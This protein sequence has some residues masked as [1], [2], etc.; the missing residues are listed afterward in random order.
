MTTINVIL[1]SVREP[2]MGNRILT[3][4]ENHQDEL[5]LQCEAHLNFIRISD[6]HLAAYNQPLPPFNTPDYVNTLPENAKKWVTDVYNA[7]GLLLLL[8]EYDF[9]IPGALKNALDYLGSGVNNKPIQSISY[10]MGGFGGLLASMAVL[11]VYQA[12]NLI[13][14][15]HNLHIKNVQNVFETNGE[16]KD[17]LSRKEQ[18]YYAG[19]IKKVVVNIAHYANLL[20]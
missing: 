19:A 9:S 13:T 18:D 16:F 6:Y 15:S 12:L 2:S 1:G 5:E 7:D 10:S 11:P 17:D 3:Y 8:P 14:L 4:L 20:K